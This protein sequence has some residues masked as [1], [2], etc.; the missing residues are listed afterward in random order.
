MS[1]LYLYRL[2]LYSIQMVPKQFNSDS[3]MKNKVHFGSTTA[4][5][6]SNNVSAVKSI[7]VDYY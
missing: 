3:V 6:S 4:Q 2:V 7:I 5:F 1:L